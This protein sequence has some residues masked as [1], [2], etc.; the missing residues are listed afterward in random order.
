MSATKGTVELKTALRQSMAMIDRAV[1]AHVAGKTLE[2]A[3]GLS[4]YYPHGRIDPSYVKTEFANDCL[5]MNLIREIH[6]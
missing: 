5:W 1:V 3:R 2:R 6:G 4:I